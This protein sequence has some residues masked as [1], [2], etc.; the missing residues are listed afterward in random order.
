MLSRRIS[1]EHAS[2]ERN[3]ASRRLL[4][5]EWGCALERETPIFAT[6]RT[7]VQLAINVRSGAAS[8]GITAIAPADTVHQKAWGGGGGGWY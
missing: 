1:R 7:R 4:C 2:F 5:N 6:T 8:V 3:E